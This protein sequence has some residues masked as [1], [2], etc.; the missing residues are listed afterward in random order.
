MKIYIVLYTFSTTNYQGADICQTAY[1][2][3]D[4]ALA[5]M[6]SKIS[7][8]RDDFITNVCNCSANEEHVHIIEKSGINCYAI[9]NN[10]T[11]EFAKLII[12]ESDLVN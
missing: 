8:V 6:Q 9:T 5:Y 11:N 7:A 4:K 12:E 1:T 3:H 2:S 10:K